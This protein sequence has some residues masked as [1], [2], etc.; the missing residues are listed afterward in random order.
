[1]DDKRTLL[2]FL[3]VGLIFL[4]MPYY[5]EWMGLTPPPAEESVGAP[6]RATDAEQEIGGDGRRASRTQASETTQLS[7]PETS[8]VR[9]RGSQERPHTSD[10]VEPISAVA[11]AV[12]RRVVIGS[13]QHRLEF[14]TRGGAL[15]GA[16]LL[17]YHRPDGRLVDLIPPGGQGLRLSLR[18]ESGDRIVR[19]QDL[20]FEPS[21]DSVWAM[22]GGTVSLT[23]RADLGDGRSIDKKIV[24]TDGEYAVRLE[25][26]FRGITDESIAFMHWDGGIALAERDAKLDLQS[27]R[28]MAYFNDSLEE[29]QVDEDEEDQ[30]DERGDLTWVGVRSKYFI[31]ALVP[32][33][34]GRHRIEMSGRPSSR[35]PFREY[36]F[37]FGKRLTSSD[38]TWETLFYA[39]PL[40]LEKVERYES[41]LTRALDL[42]FPVVRQISEV[43]MVVFVAAHQVIPNYG[44]VI[45]LFGVVVKLLVYPL[46]HKSYES[47]AKMQ[48]LQPKLT[49]LR[50]KFKSDN[51]RLS[52]ETM[53]LYKDE[54]VNPIGGCLP[55]LLQMPIFIA[56]YQVFSSAIELRQSPWIFWITDL[57]LPDEI[58][59][60]G[61]S[62]HLLPLLMATA[63]FF[64]SRMTMKDPK[65]AALVYIMPV[66]MV[67]IMWDF[68]SG[69]VL[70]W[71]VFNVLQIGQQYL[72][73]HLRQKKELVVQPARR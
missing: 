34:E 64:Q 10:E 11:P 73:N 12:E 16:Q 40:D 4:V 70:Y 62:F 2:A 8:R 23:L 17:D 49:A 52:Q 6:E 57:S 25:H 67:F 51:Q 61:F 69:L 24:V 58:D 31:A 22:D 27:M 7:E 63:M 66:V 48:E 44:W 26:R 65:Q 15:V 35:E 60:A 5:Y 21:T 50:E 1:M 41:S 30:W 13:S 18:S 28:V 46:T 54:G 45:V 72:T 38:E 71:T 29:L 43:I 9:E 20:H 53:K 14:S 33:G 19:L 32:D 47:A 39:G 55:M 37:A 59:V 42:G 68:S 56:M 3:L 36:E